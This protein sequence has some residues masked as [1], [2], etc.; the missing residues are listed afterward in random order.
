MSK[1]KMPISIGVQTFG[2]EQ[3]LSQDFDGTFARLKA[4]GFRG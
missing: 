1:Q 4:M 2:L 3:E